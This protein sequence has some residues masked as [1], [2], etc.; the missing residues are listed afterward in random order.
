M[1]R[2]PKSLFGKLVHPTFGHVSCGSGP[3]TPACF[4]ARLP[5][6]LRVPVITDAQRSARLLCVIARTLVWPHVAVACRLRGI[7]LG[8]FEFCPTPL[9]LGQLRGNAFRILMRDVNTHDEQHVSQVRAVNFTLNSR[10]QS[11]SLS[12]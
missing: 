5:A 8:N 3:P 10:Q 12:T 4:S 6:W 9:Q 1:S 2:R 11:L 7:K